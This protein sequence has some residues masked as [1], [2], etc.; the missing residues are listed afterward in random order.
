MKVISG[1]TF[2]ALYLGLSLAARAEETFGSIEGTVKYEG[3][4]PKSKPA[5]D[6]GRYR[7]LL[8]VERKTGGLLHVVVYLAGEGFRTNAPADARTG[9]AA[10]VVNQQDHTFVPHVMAVRSG[11]TVTF[12]NSDPANHNVR[13]SSPARENEFN[14]FTGSEG[15][16][17]H[18]FVSDA[19]QRPVHLTCDIHPWMSAWLFVF[20]HPH[21]A[22]TDHQGKFRISPAPPGR[23]R[24]VI[25]QP[26]VR[27]R[28]EQMV[29]VKA[30]EKT[31]VEVVVKAKELK[32]Q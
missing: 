14:V 16:Y 19:K 5:D 28:S 12:T 25:E 11:Q 15:S 22:M 2:L 8:E 31:V 26:D 20:D 3:E 18:R 23:H 30:G 4:V 7:D 27:Y 17:Q 6:A 32:V 9:P 1:R 24:L 21:F 10:A 13:A 29:T